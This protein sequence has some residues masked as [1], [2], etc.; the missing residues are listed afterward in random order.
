M[1]VVDDAMYA[2][3]IIAMEEAA[4]AAAAEAAATA[5]ATAAAETAAAGAAEAGITAAATDAA[6]TAATTTAAE[7]GGTAIGTEGT[8]AAALEGTQAGIEAAV[9]EAAQAAEAATP[10]EAAGAEAPTA[11]TPEAPAGIEQAAATPPAPA[12]A[13]APQPPAG[14]EQVPTQPATP[15]EPAGAQP[16]GISQAD[17]QAYDQMLSETQGQPVDMNA[18][19]PTASTQGTTDAG[20]QQLIPKQPL[21]NATE[22]FFENGQ[23]L[24]PKEPAGIEQV[25]PDLAQVQAS[26]Q[27]DIVNGVQTSANPTP[28]LPTSSSNQNP[29][30]KGFEWVEKNPTKALALTTTATGL[31]GGAMQGNNSMP[32]STTSTYNGPLSKYKLSP[33][34]RGSTATPNV[35]KAGYAQG[36]PVERMSQMDIPSQYPM[37]MQDHTQYATPTQMPTSAEVVR[38]DYDTKTDPRFGTQMAAGGIAGYASGGDLMTTL[39]RYNE[40]MYGRPQ[41][42]SSDRGDVGIYYDLDPDTKYKDALS[43]SQIRLDKIDKRANLPKQKTG[44]KPQPLGQIKVGPASAKED[45]RSTDEDEFAKGGITQIQKYGIGG[46]VAKF[47]QMMQPGGFVGDTQDKFYA[48]AHPEGWLGDKAE[49]IAPGGTL[50][51]IHDAAT[52]GRA[53]YLRRKR[54]GIEQKHFAA[55]GKTPILA[56]P[57]TTYRTE[58][59]YDEGGNPSEYQ[60]AETYQPSQS[61]LSSKFQRSADV[62]PTRYAPAYQQAPAPQSMGRVWSAANAPAAGIVQIPQNPGRA[63]NRGDLRRA[64]GGEVYDLG[65]YAHGGNPRL[66]QG[67]GDGMSDNIPATIGGKQPARLAD[68]EFVVPADVVSALGNGS[69]EA[70]ARELHGMMDRIRGAA[71]GKKTQQR[72]VKPGKVMPK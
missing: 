19:E 21:Q 23:Q 67:P 48:I 2:A 9:P 1:F 62:A 42:P 39:D 59:T 44:I 5:A 47:S 27:G 41:A 40:M 16:Q 63:W 52:P 28:N 6:A 12:E 58:T 60:V 50:G 61:V 22:P 7:V 33:N 57:R 24:I 36:G 43:A 45:K 56:A 68:G 18:Y 15:V 11:A 54:E 31:I 72:K 26:P 53:E 4:A 30:I 10:L 8:T 32:S 35:Y 71:H 51:Q 55:G 34:F 66:L 20:G 17:M 49:E 69:T 46:E 14:I 70:G 38:A 29:F 64:G 13:A 25:Q 37:G 65:G 3:A